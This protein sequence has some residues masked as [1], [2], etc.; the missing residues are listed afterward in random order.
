DEYHDALTNGKQWILNLEQE[1]KKVTNIK[2][3]KVGFNRVFGYYIEVTHANKHLIPEDRYERKQT[4]RNAERYITPELKEKEAIILEAEEKSIELEYELFVEV[5]E[6]IKN[7]IELIQRI[8]QMISQIDVL[9]SFA[10]VSERYNY[11]RPSFHNAEL[12]IKQSRHPV[13]ERVME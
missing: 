4:L 5:R 6:R 8:A 9:Q 10:E 3:L 13:I 11:N 12:V 1:E 7:E 2:S